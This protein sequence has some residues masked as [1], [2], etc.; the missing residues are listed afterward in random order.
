MEAKKS[1][2]LSVMKKILL[3]VLIITLF[4]VCGCRS[5]A[6]R[7]A[8]FCLGFDE[9]VQSSKTCEE[10]AKKLTDHLNG[11]QTKLNDHSLCTETTAC[12]PCRKGVR[13]MLTQ[14]GHDPA[15]RPVLD[16]LHFSKTLRE[17][18]ED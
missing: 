3:P 9:A 2:Y 4:G 15:M 16:K 5:Q 7:M 18:S 11:V 17:I 14:C 13:D 8:E 10:M 12:L 1:K 6:D